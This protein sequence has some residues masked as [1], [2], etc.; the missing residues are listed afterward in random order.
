MHLCICPISVVFKFMVHLFVLFVVHLCISSVSGAPFWFHFWCTCFWCTSVS[1]S[2][3]VHFYICPISGA[4]LYLPHFWCTSVFA[5]SHM[6]FFCLVSGALLLS[7]FWCISS[8]VLFLVHFI[9]L[10]LGALLQLF[11]FWCIS[12][13]LFL[14]HFFSCLVSGALLQLSCF[15]CTFVLFLVHFFSCLVSGALLLSCFWGTSSAVLFLGHFF[16]CLVSGALL[17]LSCFWCTSFVLFLVHFFSCLVSGALLQ[18]SC[19]WCTFVMFLVHFSCRSCHKY[20]FCCDKYVFVGTN[21]YLT[22]KH[23]FCRDKSMVATILSQQKY[24]ATKV[25]L[26]QAYFCHNKRHVLLW[27]TRVCCDMTKLILVAAPTYN[28]FWDTF[29]FILFTVHF[30]D[31]SVSGALLCLP[32]FQHASV[33]SA[34]LYFC[35][36]YFHST[37]IVLF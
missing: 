22:T 17:Q 13:V 5:L 18:L 25:S 8:A 34:L 10:V 23:V 3:L 20:H 9:C 37:A 31:Y 1:A 29:A 24:V 4:L 33:C 11:C 2:L 16:S 7:C 6:H 27:Q 12:F 19:F 32:H 36:F 15:W 28:S 14:V 26:L 35:V 21:M 30:C